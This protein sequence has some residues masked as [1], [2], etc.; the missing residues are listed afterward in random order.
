MEDSLNLVSFSLPAGATYYSSMQQIGKKAGMV[1]NADS[2]AIDL[3]SGKSFPRPVPINSKPFDAFRE[4]M[5]QTTLFAWL[6][7]AAPGTGNKPAVNVQS[8]REQP[9]QPDF[10]YGTPKYTA[11][12]DRWDVQLQ[13]KPARRSAADRA[14]GRDEDGRNDDG[15]D[16]PRVDGL[17]VANWQGRATCEGDVV[18]P[19]QFTPFQSLSPHAARDAMSTPS[20]G[21]DIMATRAARV[22]VVAR[23]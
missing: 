13:A 12:R 16:V 3:M 6:Q 17:L 14:A 4:L 8:F 11:E 15:R 23:K 10:S 7:P 20:R 2:D 18:N 9:A 5:Q 19:L 22:Q 1:I 21:F